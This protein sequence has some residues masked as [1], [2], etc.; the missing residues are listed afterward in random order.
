MW[1]LITGEKIGSVFVFLDGIAIDLYYQDNE[2]SVRIY[3]NSKLN[4]IFG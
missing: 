4:K 1:I 3:I 2:I